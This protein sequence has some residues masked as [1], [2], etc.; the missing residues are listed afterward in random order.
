MRRRDFILAGVGAA[1]LWPNAAPAQQSSGVRRI[2]VLMGFP[3]A[4][5]RAQSY[6]RDVRQKLDTLGWSEKR[7]IQIHERW[8]GGDPVKTRA[9][10]KE[11]IALSPGVILA[12]TNQAVEILRQET[13]TIP[14]VFAS[15]GDPI[16][17][18][19]VE[20]L[21]RPGGNV[22]GFPAFVD[23]M[24]GKW[25]ELIKEIAPRVT[26]IG[27][28]HHPGVAP[29]R[30]LVRAAVAAAPALSLELVPLAVTNP[31]E[32]TQAIE[33]FTPGEPGALVTASHALTYSSRDLIIGLAAKHRLPTLGGEP[34]YTESGALM[35]YG[36]DQREMFIGA[37]SYIGQILKGAKPA[38]MP[39][40][41][42]TKFTLT[43]NL[44][45]AQAI[46]ITVP[47]SLLVRADQVIE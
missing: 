39:V 4:D 8:A 10:A 7:N 25:L 42:P 19:L 18:G 11:L 26:R 14:I 34:I 36:S 17:S 15:L 43:L 27:F 23:T 3:E 2:G 47:S 35:S 5:A 37:A 13:K 28:V 6:V 32:I 29:H 24:S 41:L 31:G 33:R 16:G 20:S 45:T 22:T 46:G 40:Q 21:N 30:G 38:E 44:K 9:F 1:A 12:S